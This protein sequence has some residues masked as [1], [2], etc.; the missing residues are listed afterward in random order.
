[1]I[2][3]DQYLQF[4][5]YFA[6]QDIEKA[7]KRSMF[8]KSFDIL[9]QKLK[10]FLAAMDTAEK[11][12]NIGNTFGLDE[13]DSEAVALAVRK[14]AMGEISVGNGADFITNETELPRERAKNLLSLLVNEVLV[15]VL[16]DIKKIQSQKF[17]EKVAKTSENPKPFI[18]AKP[19][20]SKL[21]ERPDLK[22]DPEINKNNVVDLRNRQ[23]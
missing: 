13:F 12:M 5:P 1:M 9:P 10:D 21:P 20:P 23:N 17:P 14:L 7:E 15:L 3:Y 16:E 22:I 4:S 8:L 6:Q 11:I 2:S 18:S 19:M